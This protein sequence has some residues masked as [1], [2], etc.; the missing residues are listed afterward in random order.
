VH[1]FAMKVLEYRNYFDAVSAPTFSVLHT[2]QD[3]LLETK[4][5]V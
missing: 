5:A 4:F 2:R 3:E 1:D